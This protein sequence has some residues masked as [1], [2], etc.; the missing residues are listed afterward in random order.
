MPAPSHKVDL[1]SYVTNMI[2]L[3]LIVTS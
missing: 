3:K 1:R 2:F